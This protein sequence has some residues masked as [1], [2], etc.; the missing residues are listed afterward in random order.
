M[1]RSQEAARIPTPSLTAGDRLQDAGSSRE[2]SAP[3]KAGNAYRRLTAMTLYHILRLTRGRDPAR[4]SAM[5]AGIA[6]LTALPA[7]TIGP[8][9]LR[10]VNAI[11]RAITTK[12]ERRGA[13]QAG[14]TGILWPTPS[15]SAGSDNRCPI[16]RLHLTPFSFRSKLT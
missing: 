8:F 7:A 15:R 4:R 2:G 10:K 3:R 1:A 14:K 5:V 9:H 13:G 6:K 11:N 12:R 16:F